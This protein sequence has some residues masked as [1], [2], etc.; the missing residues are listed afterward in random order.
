MFSHE[1][2]KVNSIVERNYRFFRK[3][4]I[5][6]EIKNST[7]NQEYQ[8]FDEYLKS[9]GVERIKAINKYRTLKP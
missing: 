9:T 2:N 1:V 3:L 5:P 7:I 8:Q 4:N 6:I